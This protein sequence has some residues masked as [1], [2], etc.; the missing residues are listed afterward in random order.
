MVKNGPAWG[1]EFVERSFMEKIGIL[2]AE[3]VYQRVNESSKTDG[4]TEAS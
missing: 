3:S 1:V 4:E 2:T